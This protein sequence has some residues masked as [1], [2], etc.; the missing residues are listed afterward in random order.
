MK[1]D[2]NVP[3]KAYIVYSYKNH[4]GNIQLG[5]FKKLFLSEEKAKKYHNDMTKLLE[6]T[7]SDINVMLESVDIDSEEQ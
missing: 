5:K 4:Y 2:V 3:N 7:Y 6:E 1:E